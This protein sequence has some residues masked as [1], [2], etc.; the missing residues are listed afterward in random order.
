MLTLTLAWQVR[1]LER[2]FEDCSRVDVTKLHGGF[3]GSLVLKTDSY[4]LDG[5]HDEPTVT[6]L[7][8]TVSMLDEVKNTTQFTEL[9][10]AS[11]AQ[12]QRGPFLV[13]AF[14]E[15]IEANAATGKDSTDYLTMAACYPA[16]SPIRTST[17]I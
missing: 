8:D 16:A 10:G 7:D 15:T 5:S 12:V 9:V 6:K 1:L 13:D 14:G 3:S 17:T 2:A 4:G 11:A